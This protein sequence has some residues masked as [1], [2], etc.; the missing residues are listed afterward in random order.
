MLTDTI[1]QQ[2][3]ENTNDSVEWGKYNNHYDWTW[4]G[5]KPLLVPNT[6][7]VT[8]GVMM[9]DWTIARSLQKLGVKRVLDIGSDT[10][11]FIAVLKYHGIDA[12]GIDASKEACDL[13]N[14]KGQNTCY[15]L[16]VKTLIKLNLNEYDCL[17][18]M[19]ITQAVWKDEALKKDFVEW[20]G[21]HFTYTVLSDFTHQDR[22]WYSFKKI[23]DFNFLPFYYTPLIERIFRLMKL[24]KI[25]SYPCIQKLYII[26][27]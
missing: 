4:C 24:E 10:G 25:I 8:A 22:T 2:A 3:Q 7:P 11:H 6:L 14:S 16:S 13:V 15:H 9:R 21:G 1:L 18:C 17:T 26:K 20:I 12:V 27:R 5:D 23:E 19:N